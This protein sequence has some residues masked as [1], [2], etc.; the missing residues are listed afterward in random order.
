MSLLIQSEDDGETQN[1]HRDLKLQ[2][3]HLIKQ[4]WQS[5]ET[6]ISPRIELKEN[7]KAKNLK[8]HKKCFA[9][10]IATNHLTAH[11]LLVVQFVRMGEINNSRQPHSLELAVKSSVKLQCQVV[12]FIRFNLIFVA[13]FRCHCQDDNFLLRFDFQPIVNKL[14]SQILQLLIQE[15]SRRFS[16]S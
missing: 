13:A 2:I 16:T 6:R 10:Q 11:K 14:G 3:I 4:R 7:G 15:P 12:F 8:L 1:K 9:S 5:D